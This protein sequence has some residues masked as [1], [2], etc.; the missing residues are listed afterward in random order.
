MN[1][2]LL[3]LL[4]LLGCAHPVSIR[5]DQIKNTPVDIKNLKVALLISQDCAI[6]DRQIQELKNCLPSQDVAVF[7][8]GHD[9]EK[10]RRIVH[11][12]KIPFST[13]LLEEKERQYFAW[14]KITPA[15]SIQGAHGLQNFEGF[16]SCSEI[17]S[18]L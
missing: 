13:Y 2:Y 14:G 16:K 1:K 8:S 15:L 10:L 9:E 6:C 12:K 5:L 7:I 11:K 3:S 17:K 4:L 18:L